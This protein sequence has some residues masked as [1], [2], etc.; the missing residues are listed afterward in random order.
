MLQK[1]KATPTLRNMTAFWPYPTLLR[2]E[3]HKNIARIT[4]PLFLD[5]CTCKHGAVNRLFSQT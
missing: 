5:E 2:H 3:L 4:W 1:V